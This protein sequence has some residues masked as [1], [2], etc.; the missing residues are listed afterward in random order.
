MGV[1]EQQ[2]NQALRVL[3]DMHRHGEIDR[4]AY[5]QRRRAV[6]EALGDTSGAGEAA[7]TA[8]EDL[9]AIGREPGRDTVRRTVPAQEFDGA[10][11]ARLVSAAATKL[12]RKRRARAANAGR[13]TTWL[14]V[15]LGMAFGVAAVYWFMMMS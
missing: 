1:R 14:V 13:A 7:V 10:G 6:L 15:L 3:D 2:A 4:Q 5:R 11:E 8:G 9:A 12:P